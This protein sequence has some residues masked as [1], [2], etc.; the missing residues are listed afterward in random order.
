MKT[1][2]MNGSI[3]KVV[4]PKKVK[5]RNGK[6]IWGKV[7]YLK[8]TI[9]VSSELKKSSQNQTLLHEILHIIGEQSGHNFNEKQINALA[10]GLIGAHKAN[11]W[12]K[13]LYD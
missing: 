3:Y 8:E 4:F 7:D 13:K 2:K 6:P 11:K 12:M 5:A 10:Y 9:S 1:F